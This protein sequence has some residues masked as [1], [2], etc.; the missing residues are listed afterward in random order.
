MH[1]PDSACT[2]MQQSP[3]LRRQATFLNEA[4][5]KPVVG[6]PLK[7]LYNRDEDAYKAKKKME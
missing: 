2:D 5:D 3:P 7:Q 6:T 1:A 4:Y